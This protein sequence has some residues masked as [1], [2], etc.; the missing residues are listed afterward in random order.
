[1]NALS[2]G[3]GCLVE[4]GVILVVTE[5]DLASAMRSST[6]KWHIVGI[7]MLP[8]ERMVLSL[9]GLCTGQQSQG[10]FIYVF[11]HFYYKILRAS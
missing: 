4:Q 2:H 8:H 5:F 10:N 6:F 3:P 1:M 9:E 7:M 11:K